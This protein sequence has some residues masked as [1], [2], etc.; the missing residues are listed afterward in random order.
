MK[1]ARYVLSYMKKK[2]SLQCLMVSPPLGNMAKKAM[3][4][5]SCFYT[6]W[7]EV[8]LHTIFLCLVNNGGGVRTVTKLVDC[9]HFD[10]IC[11][12]FLEGS[13]SV[14]FRIPSNTTDGE[15]R[16]IAAFSIF[17]KFYSIFYKLAVP[18]LSRRRLN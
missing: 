14:S 1:N 11:C 12:I 4:R 15:F 13:Q 7:V 2:E 5:K 8:M 17:L 9:F 16:E 10:L 6:P 18:C 3:F